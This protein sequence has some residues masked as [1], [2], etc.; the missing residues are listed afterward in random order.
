MFWAYIYEHVTACPHMFLFSDAGLFSSE[1]GARFTGVI[2]AWNPFRS[3]LT[4]YMPRYFVNTKYPEAKRL[5][6]LA[7]DGLL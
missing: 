3:A 2:L 6:V 1:F 4:L 7:N 5:P